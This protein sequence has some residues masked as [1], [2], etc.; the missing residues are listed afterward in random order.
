MCL[1]LTRKCEYLETQKNVYKT[2]L[3][4]MKV[5]KEEMVGYLEKALKEEKA[6]V[7]ALILRI[8]FLNQVKRQCNNVICSFN[9]VFSISEVGCEC[10]G[11]DR[12]HRSP[13]I[14]I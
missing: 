4:E 14:S 12:I 2:Q 5:E 8:N 1:R 6:N 3:D 7:N 11:T 10:K 13:R 9:V